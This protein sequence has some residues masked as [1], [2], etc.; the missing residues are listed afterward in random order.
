MTRGCLKD[1]KA[2]YIYFTA[3]AIGSKDPYRFNLLQEAAIKTRVLYTCSIC[4]SLLH[5]ACICL[6]RQV[7]KYGSILEGF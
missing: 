4:E 2:S 3:I 5:T 7:S 6:A 1:K